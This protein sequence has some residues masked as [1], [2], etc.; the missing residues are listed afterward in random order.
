MKERKKGP[1][2]RFARTSDECAFIGPHLSRVV[3]VC[4]SRA[5]A[6][7]WRSLIVEEKIRDL[8][9]REVSRGRGRRDGHERESRGR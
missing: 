7:R 6:T 9:G 5:A 4:T 3:L 1:G 8:G 2:G